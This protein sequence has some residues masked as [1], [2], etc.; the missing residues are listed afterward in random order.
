[1]DLESFETTTSPG[2]LSSLVGD[3][4]FQQQEMLT[5]YFYRVLHTIQH[6]DS[7]SF[8]TSLCRCVI[9]MRVTFIFRKCRRQRKSLEEMLSLERK[10]KNGWFEMILY[11]HTDFIP[12]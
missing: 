8:S 10:W 11:L 4:A 9:A 2:L 12:G 6:T 5:S 7:S 1:M 3:N